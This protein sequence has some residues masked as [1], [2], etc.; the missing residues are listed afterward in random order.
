MVFSSFFKYIVCL[1]IREWVGGGVCGGLAL[2]SVH[3]LVQGGKP[4]GAKARQS[5]PDHYLSAKNDGRGKGSRKPVIKIPT[6]LLTASPQPPFI[7]LS[8]LGRKGQR[9]VAAWLKA[10][11][12]KLY[13]WR[14]RDVLENSF[15]HWNIS[16]RE[17]MLTSDLSKSDECN[18]VIS[19]FIEEERSRQEE[20]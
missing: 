15:I 10:K 13:I 6:A 4:V 9:D 17:S 14:E 2:Y 3:Y 5:L 12:D 20:R 18:I 1:F 7:S 16:K 19:L 11:R 8:G